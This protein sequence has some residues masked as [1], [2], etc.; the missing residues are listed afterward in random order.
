MSFKS[1]LAS[2]AA[3]TALVASPA[4]ADNFDVSTSA[5]GADTWGLATAEI[6]ADPVL[7]AAGNVALIAQESTSAV[8]YIDQTGLTNFAAIAQVTT[9]PD[10]AV[11]YQIGD[12]NRAAIYQHQ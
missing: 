12:L 11:I 10:L 6:A 4:F 1:K 7:S 5:T 8:A 3:L 9:S 2:I